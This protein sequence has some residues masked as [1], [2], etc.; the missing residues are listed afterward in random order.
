MS[1]DSALYPGE[2][3]A[4]GEII[5]D[6]SRRIIL[7]DPN[8]SH[9]ARAMVERAIAWDDADDEMK[10]DAVTTAW[11]VRNRVLADRGLPR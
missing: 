4:L 10:A 11:P 8:A 5:S 3:D 9:E 6:I 7:D 2:R 1:E